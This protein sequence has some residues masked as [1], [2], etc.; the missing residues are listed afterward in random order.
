MVMAN[1]LELWRYRVHRMKKIDLFLVSIVQDDLFIYIH[2]IML[3]KSSSK[4]E[5]CQ[6]K[7]RLRN[8]LTSAS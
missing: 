1:D 5:V 4:S 6:M 7:Y 3:I 8:S 2:L